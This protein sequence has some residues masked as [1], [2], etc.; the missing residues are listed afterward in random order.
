MRGSDEPQQENKYAYDR[1]N[2]IVTANDYGTFIAGV[3]HIKYNADDENALINK[4]IADSGN[5]EYKAYRDFV[6][7]IKAEAIKYFENN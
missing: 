6:A 2:A 5:A 7:E 1:Y 4:G 3:L